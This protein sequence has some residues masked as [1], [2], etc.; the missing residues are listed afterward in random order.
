MKLLGIGSRLAARGSAGSASKEGHERQVAEA[1]YYL[2]EKRGFAPG[3]EDADWYEAERSL[4][5][6]D[7][8][9]LEP[10]PMKR[11]SRR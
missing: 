5:G 1:A 10:V 7:A 4:S 6:E 11:G 3:G 8:P 2:A 9:A